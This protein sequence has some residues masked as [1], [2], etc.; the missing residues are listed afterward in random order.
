MKIQDYSG[1]GDYLFASNLS[2]IEFRLLSDEIIEADELE[3]DLHGNWLEVATEGF[4]SGHIAGVGELIEELQ[5]LEAEPGDVFEVTRC[6]KSGPRDTDP[7]EVNLEAV[8]PD[9]TRL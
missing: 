2:G 3:H 5:R 4:D 1:G 9:Q 7:Y 6:K 8:E